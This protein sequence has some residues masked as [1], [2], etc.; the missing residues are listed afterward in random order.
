MKIL[1]LSLS[2]MLLAVS[3]HAVPAMELLSLQVPRLGPS[4]YISG[5]NIQTW[6]IH[7]TQV[8]QI[9]IGW[10]ITAGRNLDQSGQIS[11]E[12]SGFMTNLNDRQLGELRNLVL[13][14]A[15]PPEAGKSVTQP[16]AFQGS[17]SVGTYAAPQAG[18]RTLPLT[19]ANLVLR[20]AQ[21]CPAPAE[22]N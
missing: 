10:M 20:P 3:A 9:P 16:P 7:V 22:E 6:R 12:A 18:E 8:C 14:D 2:F 17:I 11:G 15:P 21:A 1:C 19:A 4:F 5:F 13:I